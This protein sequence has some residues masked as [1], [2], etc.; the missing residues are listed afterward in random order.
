[1][2]ESFVNLEGLR[3]R[4]ASVKLRKGPIKSVLL[5]LKAHTK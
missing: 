4:A 3:V 5:L 2:L 1:L